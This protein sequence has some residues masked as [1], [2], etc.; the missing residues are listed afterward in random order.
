M[1][2]KDLEVNDKIIFILNGVMLDGEIL[3][4]NYLDKGDIDFVIK[5]A[6]DKKTRILHR[7][8][9]LYYKLK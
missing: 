9:N 4:K 1:K 2:T 3:E 7:N 5:V 8:L 6:N